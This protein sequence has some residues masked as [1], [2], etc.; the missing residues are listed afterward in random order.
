MDLGL[1]AQAV[2]RVGAATDL[3]AGVERVNLPLRLLLPAPAASS[4]A[5]SAPPPS[6]ATA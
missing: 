6:A 2:R 3:R 1:V 4:A 5:T